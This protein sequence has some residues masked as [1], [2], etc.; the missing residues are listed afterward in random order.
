MAV[1]LKCVNVAV[2][3]GLGTSA[4]IWFSISVRERAFSGNEPEQSIL[5]EVVWGIPTLP[6]VVVEAWEK[7][8]CRVRGV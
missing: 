1:E 5:A 6:P 4:F 8:V 3:S 7:R 2:L